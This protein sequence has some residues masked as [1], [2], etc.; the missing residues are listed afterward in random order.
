MGD[1]QEY[2]RHSH[3]ERSNES[4]HEAFTC[5]TQIGDVETHER[6]YYQ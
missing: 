4:R 3:Q 5:R 1:F 2:D 6:R